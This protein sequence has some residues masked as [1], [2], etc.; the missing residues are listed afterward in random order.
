MIVKLWNKE[1]KTFLVINAVKTVYNGSK[2]ITLERPNFNDHY[3]KDV[4][5]VLFVHDQ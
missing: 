1:R 3:K 2:T 5:K 4:W